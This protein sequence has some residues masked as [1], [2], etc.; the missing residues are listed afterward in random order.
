MSP[1]QFQALLQI[2]GELGQ[3]LSEAFTPPRLDELRQALA[4]IKGVVGDAG[5]PYLRAQIGVLDRQSSQPIVLRTIDVSYCEDQ[6][7]FVVSREPTTRTFLSNGEILAVAADRCPKCLGEWRID[8]R[9]PK[10]CPTCDVALGKDVWL[11]AA[12]GFCPFCQEARTA[13]SETACDC[14]FDWST[15]FG[16]HWNDGR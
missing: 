3:Q 1:D 9:D 7:L 10:P 5:M 2:A 12:A 6:K 16:V 14:G 8:P 15:A 11:V 13:E 4:R